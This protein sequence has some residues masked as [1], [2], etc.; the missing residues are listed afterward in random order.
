MALTAEQ[1]AAAAKRQALVD[2]RAEA[3]K[4]G[5]S[6]AEANKAK[7]LKEQRAKQNAADK[8]TKAADEAR[9]TPAQRRTD[10]AN[11]RKDSAAKAKETADANKSA[12][13]AEDSKAKE[14][15]KKAKSTTASKAVVE[16]VKSTAKDARGPLSRA[17][18]GAGRVAGDALKRAGPIGFMASTPSTIEALHKNVPPHNPKV[19]DSRIKKNDDA[20]VEYTRKYAA[21]RES[22]MSAAKAKRLMETD[23]PPKVSRGKGLPVRSSSQ[24]KPREVR[25]R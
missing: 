19:D 4:K 11:A 17:L 25:V 10:T 21:L 16:N 2:K 7:A 18:R 5:K 14:L 20:R 23:K 8:A 6:T 1:K 3:A 9:K 12:R 24:N 22:G 15:A 13:F